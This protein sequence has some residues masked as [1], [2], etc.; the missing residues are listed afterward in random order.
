[1]FGNVAVVTRSQLMLVR[2]IIMNKTK[3]AQDTVPGKL[4]GLW[5]E[6]VEWGSGSLAV[7]G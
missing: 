6:G 4:S 5:D 3:Q 7:R 2:P 1:M